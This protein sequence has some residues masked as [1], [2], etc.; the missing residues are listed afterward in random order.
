MTRRRI[1]GVAAVLLPFAADGYRRSMDDISCR[2]GTPIVFPSWGLRS[3][4]EPDL[5]TA[6]ETL[7]RDCDRFLAF[8]LGEMFLPQGR[9]FTLET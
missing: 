3:V 5:P 2:G 8:E 1:T 9:I 4:P 7:A 6:F